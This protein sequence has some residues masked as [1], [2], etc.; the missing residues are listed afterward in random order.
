MLT[1]DNIALYAFRRFGDTALR[2]ALCC[3]QHREEAEDIAQDVFLALHQSPRAFHDEEHLK[4]WLLRAIR[5]RARNYHKSWLKTKRITLSEQIP[6]EK[7]FT[8]SQEMQEL[9][10]SLPER[11][12]IVLYLYYYEGYS[13]GEIASMLEEKEN[14][15]GTWLQRGRKKL[16]MQVKESE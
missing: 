5:N 12:A 16:A 7:Q 15:I 2:F 10:F 9:I 3:T 4:A 13:I 14:T 1:D 8:E 11:Y 6:E